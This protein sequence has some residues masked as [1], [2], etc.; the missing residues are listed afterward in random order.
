MCNKNNSEMT[1]GASLQA[2][3][4]MT[5]ENAAVDAA[6]KAALDALKSRGFHAC[7]TVTLPSG[8]ELSRDNH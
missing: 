2:S 7:V 5:D 3:M 8:R 6:L 1:L 4:E